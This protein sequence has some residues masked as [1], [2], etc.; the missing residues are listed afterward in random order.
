MKMQRRSFFCLSYTY[1]GSID[2]FNSF[3]SRYVKYTYDDGSGG[4]GGGSGMGSGSGGM[5]SGSGVGSGD[6]GGGIRGGGGSFAT[7]FRRPPTA[8]FQTF[9]FDTTALCATLDKAIAD[10]NAARV[11]SVAAAPAS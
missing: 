9:A 11:A 7:R 3:S 2:A 6:S 8:A 4:G 5:G 10:A 1:D